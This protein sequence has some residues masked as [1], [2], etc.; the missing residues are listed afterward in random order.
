M[1]Q[2]R[3]IVCSL[4]QASKQS[5]A[6]SEMYSGIGFVSQGTR[7]ELYCWYCKGRHFNADSVIVLIPLSGM[8]LLEASRRHPD[9]R[10]RLGSPYVI[11]K[12][13]LSRL[14]NRESESPFRSQPIR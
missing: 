3:N 2:P 8:A 7:Q 13:C 5:T 11:T 10:R 6:D 4:I 14:P 1:I 12:T 9:S